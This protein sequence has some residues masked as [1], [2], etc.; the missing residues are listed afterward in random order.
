[1]ASIVRS[2]SSAFSRNKCLIRV[3]SPRIA[4]V[5]A[6]LPQRLLHC[7]KQPSTASLLNKTH[8]VDGW[9]YQILRHYSAKAPLTIPFITERVIL[10]LK[11]YDKIDPSKL[12]LESHFINDLGLDSLDHVEVIMA[13]EDEFGFEIPDQDAEKLNRPA[14]IVRYIADKEDVYE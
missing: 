1:M 2:V 11:L 5:S 13:M 8:Q 12:N 6:V 7:E 4:G 9:Q 14:D 3:L 10:V